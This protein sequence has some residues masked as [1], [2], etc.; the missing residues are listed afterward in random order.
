M[1]EVWD[2]G[3]HISGDGWSKICVVELGYSWVIQTQ[4]HY[5][6]YCTPY[7]GNGFVNAEEGWDDGNS[8][9]GDGCSSNCQV[10]FGFIWINKANQRSIW[11]P[12]WGN[13]QRDKNPILEECDDGNNINLDGWSGKWTV[14]NNYIWV[15]N[16]TG[17]DI[18]RSVYSNP[19]I[20]SCNFDVLKYQIIIE[21]DQI[22]KNQE[23]T[24][25]DLNIDILGQNSPY[26]VTWSSKFDKKNLIINFNSSPLLLGGID[27]K[28]RLQF[29]NAQ[30]FKS[31]HD[32]SIAELK[33]FE[34]EVSFIP[35]SELV[36][37]GSSG[38]SYTFV[39]AML[40]SLNNNLI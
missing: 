31:E 33:L 24:L 40:N 18:W 9:S 34:Y 14:E 28:I 6:A 30:A 21:F 12:Y 27:E 1:N 38:V 22:M 8:D 35:S 20:I 4:Q 23:I 17:T 10:E 32:L 39:F 19:N 3:N 29:S 15:Q 36:Q 2:D 26:S 5:I 37:S 11:T 16:A 13:G 25:F 7:C